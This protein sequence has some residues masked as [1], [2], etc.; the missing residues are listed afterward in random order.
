MS[1]REELEGIILAAAA[2]VD[3]WW[4]DAGLFSFSEDVDRRATIAE[5]F[6]RRALAALDN[7]PEGDK[8]DAH[9]RA[10]VDGALAQVGEPPLR[11]TDPILETVGEV[12]D[13]AVET[14]ERVTTWGAAGAGVALVFLGLA[15]LASRR[16]P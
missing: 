12:R 14:V 3:R 2:K 6:L 13:A 11:W 16:L 15:W 4:K 7:M 1:S 5:G 9:I 10:L 8:R